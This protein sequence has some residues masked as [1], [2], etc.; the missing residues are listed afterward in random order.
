LVLGFKLP[1][2][3]ASGSKAL[4]FYIASVTLGV[5]TALVKPFAGALGAAMAIVL[6]LRDAT[7]GWWVSPTTSPPHPSIL[8][9][10]RADL[11]L[12]EISEATQKDNQGKKERINQEQEVKKLIDDIVASWGESN[13]SRANPTIPRWRVDW[14]PYNGH[15]GTQECHIG[16]Q[17]RQNNSSFPRR[18]LHIKGLNDE[19]DEYMWGTWHLLMGCQRLESTEDRS[20]DS[21][22][23]VETRL[24]VLRLSLTE[25]FFITVSLESDPVP[26]EQ[27]VSWKSAAWF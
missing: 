19:I 1:L 21:P 20:F 7:E 8:L 3:L 18:R 23:L 13:G 27:H 11:Q 17:A 12:M 6:S 26:Q 2:T 9:L 10:P 16:D 5:L 4:G 15:L 24:T 22:H 14:W 25:S